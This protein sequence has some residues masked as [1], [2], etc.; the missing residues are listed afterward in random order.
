MDRSYLSGRSADAHFVDDFAIDAGQTVGD[1]AGEPF[2]FSE[3]QA[4]DSGMK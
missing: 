1:A 4:P 2:T 3:R